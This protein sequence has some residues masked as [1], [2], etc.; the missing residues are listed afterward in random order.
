MAIRFREPFDE[1]LYLEEKRLSSMERES[2][3]GYVLFNGDDFV[4]ISFKNRKRKEL[5]E[6]YKD[7]GY[8]YDVYLSEIGDVEE[9]MDNIGKLFPDSDAEITNLHP[10]TVN[11]TYKN[12]SPLPDYRERKR[13]NIRDLEEWN[14]LPRELKVWAPIFFE[15]MQI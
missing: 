12:Y 3:T 2:D 8:Q 11:F 6:Y 5:V 10:I 15:R 9:F 14:N 7:Q 1:A 13:R 4:F